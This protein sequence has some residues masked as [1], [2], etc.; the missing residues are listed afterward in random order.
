MLSC[1][2]TVRFVVR[3][4]QVLNEMKKAE[5]KIKGAVNELKDERTQLRQKR[6]EARE[7]LNRARDRKSGKMKAWRDN[8]AMNKDVRDMVD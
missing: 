8:R 7:S 1:H 5:D 4:M 6:N 2:A 3:A